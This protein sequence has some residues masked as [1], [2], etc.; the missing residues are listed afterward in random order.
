[1]ILTFTVW[2][3][4]TKTK[5]TAKWSNKKLQILTDRKDVEGKLDGTLVGCSVFSL[6]WRFHFIFAERVR[7]E[8]DKYKFLCHDMDA[9]FAEMAGF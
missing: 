8:K 4:K 5:P 3:S 7:N 9:T 1:M 6:I 2:A